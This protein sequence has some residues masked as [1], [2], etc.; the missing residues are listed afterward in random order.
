MRQLLTYEV[1]AVM[2]MALDTGLFV[3]TCNVQKPSGTYVEGAPDNLYVPVAG[4]QGIR[5]M[6]APKAPD[7]L[8]IQSGT[9]QAVDR[10]EKCDYRHVLL[11]KFYPGLS[12]AT[13]WGNALWHAVID[14]TS[15]L[16]LAAE[17]DSQRTQTRLS[18]EKV[19]I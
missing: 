3:S 4:L 12:P 2:P 1:A 17:T 13:N 5:C 9:M 8:N 19:S 6:D 14:G 7:R 15:Y 18:L 10:V 11:E 16:I